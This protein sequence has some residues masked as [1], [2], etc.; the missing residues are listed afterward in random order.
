MNAF[1]GLAHAGGIVCS[2][3]V[4]NV[5]P[6]DDHHTTF[7]LHF[8][9]NFASKA[10]IIGIDFARFQRAG[11]GAEH[12]TA[13]RGN[14]VI[15]GGSV[16]LGQATLVDSVVLGDTA[17]NAEHHWLRLSGQMRPA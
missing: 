2:Q 5:C 6:P 16:R 8:T 3:P 15:N 17:V 7:T 11:K 13:E 12:S 14:N 4:S 1:Y 9:A 10:A